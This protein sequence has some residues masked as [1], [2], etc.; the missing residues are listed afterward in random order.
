[1]VR[2]YVNQ[3]VQVGLETTSGTTVPADK[4]LLAYRVDPAPVLET[5][6]FRPSGFMVPTVSQVITDQTEADFE[7]P[8]DFTNIV[9]PLSSIFG[10]AE[11][12]QPASVP[13]PTVY[14]WAWDFTGQ[15][16]VTPNTFTVEVGDSTRASRFNYA[17][18]TG[19][20]MSIERRGDNTVSGSM[21]GRNLSTGVTLTADP[22]AIDVIPVNAGDFDVFMASTGA[23]LSAPTKLTS[24]YT[25]GLNFGDILAAE[26][27][28]NSANDSFNSLYL[29]EDPTFEWSMT[30]GADAVGEGFLADIRAGTKRFIR[31]SATG[32]II[33][34]AYAYSIQIDMCVVV[35]GIDAYASE[36]GILA[37]PVTFALAYDATWGSAMQILVRNNLASL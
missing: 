2:S 7:G 33:E 27:T 16:A 10:D 3:G 6:Q 36:D 12:T 22:D 5:S 31:L 34:D 17:A 30:L 25:A 4:K 23:G 8:I 29:A 21:I 15:G 19:M 37:L 14:E 28:I 26:Y 9:Y 32:P 1:M 13:S 35:T 20:E 18:F 11:I 24:L